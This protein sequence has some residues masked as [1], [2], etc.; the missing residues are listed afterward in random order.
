MVSPHDFPSLVWGNKNIMHLLKLYFFSQ[1]Y[2]KTEGLPF[3]NCINAGNALSFHCSSNYWACI[4]RVMSFMLHHRGLY[5][6]LEGQPSCLSDSWGLET[7]R[8][9][10]AKAPETGSPATLMCWEK[11]CK[12]HAGRQKGSE[13]KK[14]KSGRKGKRARLKD[15]ESVHKG[16]ERITE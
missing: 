9:Q 3:T 7:W 8:R 12:D 6:S 15:R 4:P 5:L 11:R 13:W 1:F 2:T 16:H 10:R 14:K